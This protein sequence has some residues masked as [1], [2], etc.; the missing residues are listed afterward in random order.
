MRRILIAAG[1]VTLAIAPSAAYSA[2]T[3]H[4]HVERRIALPGDGGWDYIALDATWRRL[5]VTHGTH[6]H[7]VDLDSDSVVG[8]IPNTPGVHGVAF[9]PEVNRGFTSNGRDS[10][11]TVFDLKSLAVI[12]RIKLD[13][14]FPDAIMYEPVSGR[15]FTFNAGSAN[16]TA[17]NAQT[18][19]VE[20]TLALGGA[21]EA[22]VADGTGRVYVNLE[23]SS[24][25]VTFDARTLNALYRWSLAPGEEPTGLALDRVHHRLFAGC[26][27]K[28]LIVLDASSGKRVAVLPIG[29]SVDGVA[30]DSERQLVLSS[31]GDGTLTVIHENTPDKYTVVE[32]V[33]TERGGRTLALDA[34]SGTVYIPTAKF[35]PPP[36]PT[37]DRPHP[38]PSIVPGTFHVMVIK[39]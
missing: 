29:A 3:P 18:G 27:N 10:S 39:Q 32:N 16:T 13:A 2:A 33:V 31:N 37:A 14:R 9:A 7:V 12:S 23:D 24:A 8:D 36:A 34:S 38:R 11:V 4:F 1:V 6:V 28:K 25:V 5:F 30:F 17:I 19:A 22:G 15:V 35:G 21:P 20:G 26:A